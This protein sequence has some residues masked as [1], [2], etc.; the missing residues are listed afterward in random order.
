MDCFSIFKL[1]PSTN[2]RA[3]ELKIVVSFL[4]KDTVYSPFFILNP[5]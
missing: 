1:L 2:E 3:G 4:Q 5:I